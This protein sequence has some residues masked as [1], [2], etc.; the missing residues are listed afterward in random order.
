LPAAL[1]QLV[2]ADWVDGGER[3]PPHLLAP[4]VGATAEEAR[5]SA[6]LTVAHRRW[7]DARWSWAAE[8]GVDRADLPAAKSYLNTRAVRPVNPP[9]PPARKE[10]Q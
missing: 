8:H 3:L 9:A 6:A 7:R 5:F 4:P 1:V 10:S 2:V